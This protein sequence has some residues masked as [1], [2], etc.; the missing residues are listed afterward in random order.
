MAG[1]AWTFLAR[2]GGEAVEL[3][4]ARSRS[5]TVRLAGADQAQCSLDARSVQAGRI[6]ETATDLLV[7]RDGTLLHRGRVGPTQ[8]EASADRHT[9]TL[10]AVGY[11]AVLD[12]RTV[13]PADAAD[14]DGQGNP[15]RRYTQVE[16]EEIGWDL[17]TLT[18]A[19]TG[20][21]LGVTRGA[22]QATGRLRD[23]SYPVGKSIGEAIAQL[24][25]VSDGF[26][27]AIT[28]ELVYRVWYPR[29]GAD[30]GFVLDY[31][32]TVAAF[33]RSFNPAS[34][35]NAHTVSGSEGTT[36]EAREEAAYG[37]EGRWEAHHGEPDISEQTTLAARADRVHA[38]ALAYKAR[39]TVTLTAG[40]WDGPDDLW[41]GDT[42]VLAV[43]SGRLDVVERVRVVEMTVSPDD[44]GRGE[45]VGV[46][47]AHE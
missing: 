28:P 18:Q 24:S 20:G 36:V 46:T 33:S 35:A 22:D 25:N 3:T 30:N 7:Y 17:I 11:E 29:R 9:V 13:W 39:W 14:T 43:R 31:E 23:R 41:V 8:D 19:R 27:W 38:D 45:T 15:V 42:A 34:F 16:Q 12:R 40:R 6:V 26:D 5:L 37:A 47:L 10:T 44:D 2:T 21:D 1:H 4:R 32:G